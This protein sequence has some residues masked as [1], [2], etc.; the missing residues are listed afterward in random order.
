M[1]LTFKEAAFVLSFANGITIENMQAFHSRMKQWQKMGFPDGVN[2]G[3]GVRAEYGA[4]QI[5]QLAIMLKLMRVG[6]TPERAQHVVK[7]AW[8]TFKDSIIEAT[9]CIANGAPHLHY[10]FIQ[11]DALSDLK[12]DK[13]GNMPVFVDLFTSDMLENAFFTLE[14]ETEEADDFDDWTEEEIS[15][16]NYLKFTVK[17]R[18]A[19]SISIEMDS[20][21]LLIWTAMETIE[22]PSHIFSSELAEWEKD[23]RE[24]RA[25]NQTEFK[26]HFDPTYSNSSII[27]RAEGMDIAKIAYQSFRGPAD[28]SNS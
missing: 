21:L 27:E 7:A 26:K 24:R 14:S 3:R 18:L 8:I 13:K 28:D 5:Y 10:C 6:L 17:N 12:S 1:S 19:V 22:K 16:H 23:R 4:T 25:N 20:L 9:I 15:F 11:T 2:V